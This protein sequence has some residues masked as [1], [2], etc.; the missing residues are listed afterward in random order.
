MKQFTINY[1]RITLAILIALGAAIP[2]I[3]LVAQACGGGGAN[4]GC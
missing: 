4:G 2:F 3:P 1:K